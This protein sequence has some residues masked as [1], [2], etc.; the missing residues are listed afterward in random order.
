MS[1]KL[2]NRYAVRHQFV[3]EVEYTLAAESERQ[4]FEFVDHVHASWVYW[5]GR[6]V[7]NQKTGLENFLI[8]QW[9]V[10]EVAGTQKNLKVLEHR[11]GGYELPRGHSRT[12]KQKEAERN[13]RAK[14]AQW[15]VGSSAYGMAVAGSDVDTL[16]LVFN[17]Y[18]EKN[19][20]NAFPRVQGDNSMYDLMC[21][22]YLMEYS[23][24]HYGDVS[25]DPVEVYEPY[26]TEQ[27]LNSV[28]GVTSALLQRAL[29]LMYA[30]SGQSGESRMPVSPKGWAHSLRV[31]F[32]LAYCQGGGRLRHPLPDVVKY[33]KGVREGKYSMTDAAFM[34]AGVLQSLDG[35][36]HWL[37]K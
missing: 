19:G 15:V 36:Y 17:T 24:K 6:L 7:Y 14:V 3:P 11:L 18:E 27:F 8:Q 23:W 21:A 31:A 16:T 26:T 28:G 32:E 22:T 37:A 33:C 25:T 5:F 20:L 34:Q 12:Q 13:S 35:A 10:E 1:T 30:Y 9:G 4:V 2:W 29:Q